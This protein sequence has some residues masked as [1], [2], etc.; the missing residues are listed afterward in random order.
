MYTTQPQL[1]DL[2][3]LKVLR[4]K[5]DP[6]APTIIIFHG[7]GASAFDLFSL[8][9]VLNVPQGTNWIF[10]DGHLKIPLGPGYF[11]SAWFPID[12]EALQR[13]VM[14]GTVRDLT[15][16]T[17]PGLDLA[18]KNAL[19]MIE[20]SGIKL[21]NIV[22]GGFSQGAM[23]STEI[24]LQSNIRPKGLVLLSGTLLHRNIWA[25]LAKSKSSLSFF[26]SHGKVD[27]VLGFK[28]AK[29]LNKLLRDAGMVGEFVEFNGGH[30][31]PTEVIDGLNRYLKQILG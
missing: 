17:H 22:I 16:V 5:G 7:Y 8:H 31:I 1:E 20:A 19:E 28:A 26:Q 13:A 25:D 3:P 23:L 29:E 2:G 27:P 21:D 10:P 15:E 11:G 18:R 4:V 30:E 14:M 12:M 24:T 6:S 9:Q